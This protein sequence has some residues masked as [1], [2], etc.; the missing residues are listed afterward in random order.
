MTLMVKELS[1][2]LPAPALKLATADG[3]EIDLAHYR[4]KPVLVSFLS[5]AA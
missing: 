5:H 1:R 2:E 4:G 3:R